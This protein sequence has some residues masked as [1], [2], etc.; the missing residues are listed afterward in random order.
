MV[1]AIIGTLVGL[2]LPAVQAARESARQSACM[3]NVKQLA[4]AYQNYHD[5]N[6]RV[7]RAWYGPTTVP[8]RISIM[9]AR[10][11]AVHG[12]MMS[13]GMADGSVRSLSSDIDGTTWWALC[14]PNGGDTPG[15]Y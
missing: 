3:N 9:S 8:A 2:L 12:S 15:D 7:A 6:R 14:T 11:Q 1:I 13:A 5:A 10:T 4:V